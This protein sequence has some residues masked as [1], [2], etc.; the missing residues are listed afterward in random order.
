MEP[1]TRAR[2]AAAG[3]APAEILLPAAGVD[4]TRF[5][6]VACDQYSAQPE[7][8]E[9]VSAFVGAAPSSLAMMMPEAWLGSR[10]EHERAIPG[11]M[12]RF[13]AD[14]TLVSQ[15][16]GM[17][18]L[19][20]WTT[21]GVRRGLVLA[22]DLEQY[23][24]TPGSHSLIR[25]TEQTVVERLP[26]R[27]AIRRA[28]PIEM[29]HILVLLDDRERRLMSLLD[30]VTEG[31]P[32][33]YDFPLMRQSGRL[34]GWMLREE[35]TLRAVADALLALKERAA[36]GMLYAMGDGNHSFAAAK[37]HWD[38]LRPTL[39]PADRQTHPARWAL[40]ELVDLHDP[41][42]T[43]EPIHRLLLGVDPDAVQREAGFDA[44]DPPPLQELQPR[45][46]A[47][48]AQHPEAGLEY[49]H[50]REE[51]LRL[52]DAP[53]RLAIVWDAFSRDTLFADVERH[54][55]LCRKSFSMGAACDKR[56]Y[57]ECRRIR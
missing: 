27:I 35:E 18:F 3:A 32:P 56:F 45:L 19:H 16:E 26:A 55:V 38:A 23:D 40:A 57:L 13:L 12:A 14:G 21:A 5:S 51:C 28:A 33:A 9:E 36:D 25:A 52:G 34:T 6:C 54:G 17:V 29:P 49:I 37:A 42:L 39:P 20:R 31:K 2:L 44:A 50:G 24:F 15:G 7:Y 43:F 4:L 46:D 11:A 10:P 47:W 41:A 22:L 8:W 48:L 53:D 1:A 30:A